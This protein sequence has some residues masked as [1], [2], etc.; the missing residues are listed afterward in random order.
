VAE[1][2][3]PLRVALV[4]VDGA[5]VLTLVGELDVGATSTARALVV[6]AMRTA[7]D[8]LVVDLSGLAYLD[9]SGIGWLVSLANQLRTRRI[10][11]SIVAAIVA[12]PGSRARRVLALAGLEGDLDLR[13]DLSTALADP[14]AGLP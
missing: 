12:A 13:S 2:S 1:G 7:P 3:P 5:A 10:G 6:D 14:A 9:S 8:R 11:L 4:H